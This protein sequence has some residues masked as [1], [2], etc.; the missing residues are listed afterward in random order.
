MRQAMFNRKRASATARGASIRFWWT[1]IATTRYFMR[2]PG[3]W[4]N[5][6][7]GCR[8]LECG[9]SASNCSITNA[10]ETADLIGLYDGLLNA[11]RSAAEI[12]RLLRWA[13]PAGITRGTW[14]VGRIADGFLIGYNKGL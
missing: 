2:D 7:L 4:W 6:R 1:Q 14:S 9:I 10:K 8:A 11:R 13:H 12:L 3:A 5:S